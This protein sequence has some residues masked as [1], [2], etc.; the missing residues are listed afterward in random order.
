[1]AN[2]VERRFGEGTGSEIAYMGS[3]GLG[4]V[5]GRHIRKPRSYDQYL[6][7]VQRLYDALYNRQ[8]GSP[9]GCLFCFCMGQRMSLV[10]D[11]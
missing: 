9:I 10:A 1:M 8:L 3:G 5:G 6:C 2:I 7:R 4:R 11:R